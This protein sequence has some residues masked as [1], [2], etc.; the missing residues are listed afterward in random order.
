MVSV[1]TE[2]CDRWRGGNL[3]DNTGVRDFS[4]FLTLSELE[5]D[6]NNG[7]AVSMVSFLCTS[8]FISAHVGL[9]MTLK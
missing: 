7:R 1:V 4:R 2:V 6:G 9:L 5:F 3:S 8:R